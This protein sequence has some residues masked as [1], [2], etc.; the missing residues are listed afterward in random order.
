[1]SISFLY[2]FSFIVGLI[3]GLFLM[4]VFITHINVAG[5]LKIDHNNPE[6]D[7]YR[8]VIDDF[9]VLMKKKR[10]VL[11]VDDKADLSQK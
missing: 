9:N 4:F 2:W 1:M 7:V 6:K 11:K 8:F 10:I 3:L 5:T